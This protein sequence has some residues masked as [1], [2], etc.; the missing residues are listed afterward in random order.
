VTH[1]VTPRYF[2]SPR[3]GNTR[4]DTSFPV[5]YLNLGHRGHCIR[6]SARSSPNPPV[7][8]SATDYFPICVYPLAPH[9]ATALFHSLSS[10]PRHR[11]LLLLSLAVLESVP[12][13]Y[14]DR[15][16]RPSS[17]TYL[18]Q[19]VCSRDRRL[20]RLMPRGQKKPTAAYQQSAK[21]SDSALL[22]I[23]FLS[24]ATRIFV[25]TVSR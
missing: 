6:L 15:P 24:R 25:G 4:L 13:R 17:N 12:S 1:L 14:G 19:A 2:R 7:S 3:E 20:A 23:T 5:P 21:W 10:N 16:I 18:F 8:S 11:F 9:G 22:G